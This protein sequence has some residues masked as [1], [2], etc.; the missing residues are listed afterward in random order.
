[1][2]GMALMAA[3]IGGCAEME[4]GPEPDNY[5]GP[6]R[7]GNTDAAARFPTDPQLQAVRPVV[8]GDL[9]ATVM[10]PP[11][12]NPGFGVIP[13]T[14]PAATMPAA[15]MP[16]VSA[17]TPSTM[18]MATTT[19]APDN[20]TASQGH[21]PVPGD[22]SLQEAIL[23]G[24]QNNISLRVNRYNV[25]IRRTSEETARA[26]FDPT[27]SG[28]IQGGASGSSRGTVTNSI[29]GTIGV[30]EF[31][32]TGTTISASGSTSNDFYTDASSSFGGNVT[33]TQA[34]L[35]GAGMD[36]NLASLRSAKLGTKITQYQLRGFAE[37]LVA[38][39]ETTYWDLA[40]AERNMVIVQQ[41]L[42]VAKAQLDETNA[43]IRVERLAPSERA[44]AEAQVAL[45]EQTLIQAQSNLETTRLRFLQL[46]TPA[47]EPFWDRTVALHTQPFVPDGALDPIE[48]HVVVA[49]KFRPEINET[50]LEIQQGD[51]QVIQTKN[52]L[53]PRL[54]LFVTLG[55]TGFASS[56]GESITGLNGPDYQAVFGVK[57]D[58]DPINRGP[59]ASY[60]AA[61][62]SREQQEESYRN[63]VQTVQVDVRT[64]YL[65]VIRARQQIDASRA[66]RVASEATYNTEVAKFRAQR[67][68]SLLVAQ[69][70]RDLLSAQLTE[71]QAVTSYLQSLVTLYRLEGTLLYRRGLE[72][73][74]ALPVDGIAWLK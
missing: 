21:V 39:I 10:P 8:P 71:V 30:D 58:W 9:G 29:S 23:V 26:R 15:T 27:V 31:L 70:Q 52:G 4:L 63:L 53:L 35:R 33:V 41:A 61:V 43:S 5:V 50:K 17:T 65:D 54:D 38:Q 28:S 25:P 32:P 49:L 20:G 7:Q 1:M 24:L 46:I 62:L 64:Q 68:T 16:G 47:G 67:S 22:L 2:A 57:G 37:S 51:L 19:P 14:M 60:R 3:L 44:A 48:K 55:K 45:R 6:A 34:L 12:T 13:A 42:D 72:A 59:N 56:F 73:P 69:T 74:G 36:V 11:S 66:A 40:T 18:P